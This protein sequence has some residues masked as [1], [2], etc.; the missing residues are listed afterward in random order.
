MKPEVSAAV[1]GAKPQQVLK[2]IVTAKGVHLILVEEVVKP[3]LDEKLRYQI[4]SD[5][6]KVWVKQQVEEVEVLVYKDR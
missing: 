4:L 1:F 3:Q 2:P 6:F 5:L